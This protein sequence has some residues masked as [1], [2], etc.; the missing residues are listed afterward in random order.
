[1]L[2]RKELAVVLSI[3]SFGYGILEI[4]WRGHT[5][6]SM[7]VTGG[8]SFLSVYKTN[9][10]CKNK[11][12]LRR[13]FLFSGIITFWEFIAGCLFNKWLHLRVWDYSAHRGNVLGQICPLY[14]FLWFILAFPL[15]FICNSVA[16]KFKKGK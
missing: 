4:L 1:M 7:L 11:S 10:K 9:A 6:W 16:S 8:I 13:C 3:G 12:I 15:V 14:S 5:H 2:K